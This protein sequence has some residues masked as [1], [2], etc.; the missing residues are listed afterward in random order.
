M[1]DASSSNLNKVWHWFHAP[2]F[3]VYFP[4]YLHSLG[5]KMC[6]LMK[7]ICDIVNLSCIVIFSVLISIFRIMKFA[8]ERVILSGK[9]LRAA[10]ATAHRCY[11]SD[12]EPEG[13]EGEAESWGRAKDGMIKIIYES[14]YMQLHILYF[15]DCWYILNERWKMWNIHVQTWATSSWCCSTEQTHN[16]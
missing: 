8:N 11:C 10:Q 12:A 2:S 15:D 9:Y 4:H 16:E 6:I 3:P 14:V 7:T 13:D 5:G 1:L